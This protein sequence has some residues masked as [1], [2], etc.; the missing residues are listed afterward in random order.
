MKKVNLMGMCCILLTYWLSTATAQA[1]ELTFDIDGIGNGNVMPQEYGDNI[2]ALNMGDFHYGAAG[3][4]TPNVMVSYADLSGNNITYWKPGFNDLVGVLN[5]EDDG[6][7]G[8]S[9]TFTA[10]TGFDVSLL[11]FDLGNYGSAVTLPGLTITDGNDNI[12][13]SQ[14]NFNVSASSAPH[15]GFDFSNI[16]AHEIKVHVDTTGLGG[17]SDNIGLDNIQFSQVAAVPVPAAIWLFGSGLLG[18]LSS[19]RNKTKDIA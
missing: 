13:Y 18:L 15:M 9:V 12:L 1:S 19:G 4:F 5:N 11:G 16:L 2:T 17:N 7:A 14:L 6:E 10:D 3:G 8:Y